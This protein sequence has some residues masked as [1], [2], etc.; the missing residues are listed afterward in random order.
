MPTLCTG[1]VHTKVIACKD[2]Q[3]NP[4]AA[5]RQHCRVYQRKK[6]ALETKL[7]GVSD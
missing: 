6:V 3:Q 2:I 1:T 5:K 7:Y 4:G